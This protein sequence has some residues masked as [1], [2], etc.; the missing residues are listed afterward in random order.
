MDTWDATT[1]FAPPGATVKPA[2]RAQS[3]ETA[4]TSNYGSRTTSASS[5]ISGKDSA[6]P[7][8]QTRGHRYFASTWTAFRRPDSYHPPPLDFDFP[9]H[10]VPPVSNTPAPIQDPA[11]Q[12]G[13]LLS[14]S[15][16]LRCFRGHSRSDSTAPMPSPEPALDRILRFFGITRA[17]TAS[18]TLIISQPQMSPRTRHR[19]EWKYKSIRPP[20]AA[21]P[22]LSPIPPS[23][24]LSTMIETVDN[25]TEVSRTTTSHA[26]ENRSQ[27]PIS[28]HS[29]PLAAEES[30]IPIPA[31][32]FTKPR[33]LQASRAS[34]AARR[35]RTRSK[36]RALQTRTAAIGPP[37]L[38]APPPLLRPSSSLVS[39]NT[40]TATHSHPVQQGP[41]AG[42]APLSP[43][44][45][46]KS[47]VYAPP[48]ARG[49]VYAGIGIALG[50]PRTVIVEVSGA[51][52]ERVRAD[53]E[54]G[55]GRKRDRV[56]T[57][58]GR[59]ESQWSVFARHPGVKVWSG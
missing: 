22:A 51:D 59:K 18:K 9:F 48:P 13:L 50:S 41:F 2:M 7:P 57:F 8:A 10:V 56:A 30:P 14:P 29:A 54:A 19:M 5:E 35:S 3:F 37:P 1:S 49:D 16:A 12:K 36:S 43:F 11:D 52:G 38:E 26:T 47:A 20:T 34:S 45:P 6:P 58:E 42:N 21:S 27:T 15:E 23:P 44:S 40:K 32:L 39:I 31:P 24:A 25:Q 4:D 55:R 46:L 53:D 33:S 17:P 28:H